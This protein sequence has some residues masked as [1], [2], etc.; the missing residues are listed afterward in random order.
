MLILAGVFLLLFWLFDPDGFLEWMV[1]VPLAFVALL[2]YGVQ[3][4]RQW[5][6]QYM[7]EES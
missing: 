7:E 5:L 1:G 2:V 4:Y 6:K 3:S